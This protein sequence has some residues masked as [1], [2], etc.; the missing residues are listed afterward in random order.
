MS[1]SAQNGV[2]PTFVVPQIFRGP[3][4]PTAPVVDGDLWMDTSTDPGTWKG[5]KA[6]SG[7]WV[8]LG[9][10]GGGSGTVTEVATGTGLTGGPVTTS[11]TISLDDTA[12]TPGS[13]TNADITVDAQGRLTAAANGSS[14]GAT[15]LGLTVAVGQLQGAWL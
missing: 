10:G 5:Y 15:S 13:Y 2:T 7:T 14:G 12:V 4:T 8:S 9:G 1:V 3:T 6:S 11:G